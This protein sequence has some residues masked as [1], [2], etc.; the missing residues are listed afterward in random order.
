[1]MSTLPSGTTNDAAPFASVVAGSSAVPLADADSPTPALGVQPSVP[2]AGTAGQSKA[3][4]VTVT[5]IG[6]TSSLVTSPVPSPVFSSGTE[7]S[8]IVSGISPVPVSPSAAPPS[9]VPPSTGGSLFGSPAPRS[10][11]TESSTTS[12]PPSAVA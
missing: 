11:T 3:T 4:T 5:S 9:P 2:D 7:P 6:V 8:S 12:P 10:S 1:M